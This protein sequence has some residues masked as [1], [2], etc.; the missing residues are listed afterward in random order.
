MTNRAILASRNDEVRIIN[1]KILK[2]LPG[3]IIEC[4]SIDSAEA[5][6]GDDTDNENTKLQYQNEY[7][8]TLTP[9][10]F[11]PASLL[12]KIGCIVMLLR[13]MCINDG[14]CNGSRLVV[15]RV[16]KNFPSL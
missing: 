4:I 14:L 10:G 5:I 7:L 13:N 1:S 11:P 12:L 8:A 3:D 16:Q 2:R 15:R 6:G 9:S